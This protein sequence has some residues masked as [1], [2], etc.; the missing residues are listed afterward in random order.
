MSIFLTL[1]ILIQKIF[2]FVFAYLLL[3]DI[4]AGLYPYADVQDSFTSYV[5]SDK[6]LYGKV[7]FTFTGIVFS[8]LSILL[9]IV[10]IK[11][12]NLAIVLSIISILEITFFRLRILELNKI[13]FLVESCDLYHKVQVGCS[14]PPGF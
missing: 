12:K 13:V 14:I 10:V 5:I 3:V 11:L 6:A 1:L 8:F 2:N 7:F 4:K 9:C